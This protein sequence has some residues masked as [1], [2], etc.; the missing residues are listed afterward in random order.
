MKTELQYRYHGI[1]LDGALDI[2]LR[3]KTNKSAIRDEDANAR[4]VE[5]VHSPDGLK[6][7]SSMRSTFEEVHIEAKSDVWVLQQH[8]LKD[9]RVPATREGLQERD[10]KAR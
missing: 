2:M 7:A 9:A 6:R 3:H 8:V 1:A 5:K 4:M 10:N